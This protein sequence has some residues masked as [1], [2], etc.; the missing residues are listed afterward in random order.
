VASNPPRKRELL[1]EFAKALKVLAL[2]GINLRVGPFQIRWTQNA[3]RAM[4]RAGKK[5]HVQIVF[6]DQPI[7]MDVDKRQSRT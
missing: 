5:D 4:S 7:Q 6:L 2:V 1:K 3:R